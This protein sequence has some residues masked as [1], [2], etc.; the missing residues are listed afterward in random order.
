MPFKKTTEENDDY[1]PSERLTAATLEYKKLEATNQSSMERMYGALS[2]TFKISDRPC[3]VQRAAVIQ[4]FEKIL[5]TTGNSVE[6]KDK[7]PGGNLTEMT[8]DSSSNSNNAPMTT[9][10]EFPPVHKCYDSVL[11]YES[12]VLEKS[13]AQHHSLVASFEARHREKAN[14]VGKDG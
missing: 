3:E 13:L 11:L 10:S 5:G 1:T 8:V 9:T 14:L 2:S 6:G 12:C 7:G 4:C